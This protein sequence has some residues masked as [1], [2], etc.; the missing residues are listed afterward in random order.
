MS[1]EMERRARAAAQIANYGLHLGLL[2]YQ[3]D[4]AVRIGVRQLEN[5]KSGARAYQA[6]RKVVDQFAY[7][8]FR[9]QA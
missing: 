4:E 1:N 2:P 9:L 6:G 3:I 7:H 8:P 5:G